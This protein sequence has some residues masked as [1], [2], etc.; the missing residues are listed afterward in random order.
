MPQNRL[1]SIDLD[2]KYTTHVK[3]E[4]QNVV[5]GCP[6]ETGECANN[7][8]CMAKNISLPSVDKTTN[9]NMCK[10]VG[11]WTGPRCQEEDEGDEGFAPRK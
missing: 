7:G 5:F 11:S 1:N 9:W 8:I 10:C 4:R 6:C 3:V 2:E